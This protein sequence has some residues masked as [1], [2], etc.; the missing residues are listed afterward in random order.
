MNRPMT[1]LVAAVAALGL[2]GCQT[3]EQRGQIPFDGF[4]FR[5]KANKVD[6][7]D[8][9]LF[10][11]TSQPVSASLD[12]ARA[13][14]EYEGTR[15]CIETYGTSEIIWDVGPET[16]PASLPIDKDALTYRGRCVP[17]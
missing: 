15:Y 3:P 5:T 11:S 7:A 12:G 10:V 9:S 17:K 16:D 4:Y 8:L 6:K 2:A 1:V 13:A 14:A